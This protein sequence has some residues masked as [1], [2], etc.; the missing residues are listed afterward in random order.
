M[1]TNSFSQT[2]I[3]GVE[4]I[5]SKNIGFIQYNK[6]PIGYY[7]FYKDSKVD[8]SNE[9]NKLK[10]YDLNFK[11]TKTIEIQTPKGSTLSEIAFNSK[12][13][14]LNFGTAGKKFFL[15][16]DLNGNKTGEFYF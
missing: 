13:F 1:V 7:I 10:M 5:D 8:K 4:E 6:N 2:N 16:Y 14:L 11:E 9:I 15:G 12:T 3:E